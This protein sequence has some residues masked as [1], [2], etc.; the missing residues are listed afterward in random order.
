[1]NDSNQVS[2]G[3]VVPAYNAEKYLQATLD[4]IAAQTGVEVCCVISDDG[5]TDST[6]AIANAHAQK[7]DRFLVAT[8][9]NGGQSIARNRGIEKM[10]DN[11]KYLCFCDADD[12]ILPGAF[13]ALVKAVESSEH[14]I[15]GYGYAALID[16]KGNAR[17]SDGFILRGRKRAFLED[18]RIVFKISDKHNSFEDI[19]AVSMIYPPAVAIVKSGHARYV[20]GFDNK[21]RRGSEWLFFAN[22]LA[23]GGRMI[24]LDQAVACY[25]KHD[26]NLSIQQR[27][28]V[29]LAENYIRWE[30]I[31]KYGYFRM[32]P[33]NTAY[34]HHKLNEVIQSF[35]KSH[36]KSFRLLYRTVLKSFRS[37]TLILL[38]WPCIPA[39][40][41]TLIHGRVINE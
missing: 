10:P 21:L 16:G 3:V 26:N 38:G 19:A 12:L 20:K 32:R 31:R 36:N 5:S 2:V 6:L 40:R 24:F 14:A 39:R 29:W 27:N 41:R 13:S 17:P 4:S 33:I 28:G 15:G 25:R 30:L 35:K 18:G 9:P 37:V 7:D 22:C 11:V 1:M 34:Q 8:G 23:S